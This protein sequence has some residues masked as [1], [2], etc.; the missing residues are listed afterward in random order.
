MKDT[1]YRVVHWHENGKDRY[2]VHQ[3]FYDKKG[4]PQRI[5]NESI[6]LESDNID[7]L[8]DQQFHIA[9]AFLQDM[10]PGQLY[11]SSLSSDSTGDILR[12]FFKNHD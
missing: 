8:K 5:A 11:G 1:D 10:L 7:V 4:N 2:A 12:T 9:A 3:V 6:S